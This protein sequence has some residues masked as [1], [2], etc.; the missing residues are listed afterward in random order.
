MNEIKAI[1][2]VSLVENIMCIYRN[3]FDFNKRQKLLIYIR[4]FVEHLIILTMEI[5]NV[6]LSYK[7]S[8]VN[9]KDFYVVIIYSSQL[10][11]YSI[12]CLVL[13]LMNFNVY[14]NLSNMI[15]SV[16]EKVI[17]NH[18]YVKFIKQLNIMCVMIIVFYFVMFSVVIFVGTTN[19]PTIRIITIRDFALI[20]SRISFEFRYHLELIAHSTLVMIIW[21]QMNCLSSDVIQI[22][23]KYVGIEKYSAMERRMNCEVILGQTNIQQW[24]VT[25][26]Q[27]VKAANLIN[28]CFNGQVLV[29]LFRFILS[30][31]YSI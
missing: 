15:Y 8:E 18:S 25:Y 5:N 21:K 13:S 3:I 4:V 6:T 26:R 29:K 9:V 7:Y 22:Q 11:T 17:T 16:H 23:D 1:K 31:I 19:S 10:A 28:V 30:I 2:F 20:L 12:T 27:L 14:K 24:A